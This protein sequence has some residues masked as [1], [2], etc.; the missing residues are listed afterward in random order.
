MLIK[1]LEKIGLTNKEARVYLAILELGES[2]INQIAKKSEIKRSTVYDIVEALQEEGYVYSTIYNKKK[3]YVAEN[4]GII[5]KKLEE[6]K[7]MAID[8]FPELSSMAN[9]SDK[10]PQIM[11]YYGNEGIKNLFYDTLKYPGQEVLAWLSQDYHKHFDK[12]FIE[13]IYI[14]KRVKNKI[15]ERAIA[16]DSSKMCEY[17]K[18]DKKVLRE[19]KLFKKEKFPF[20]VHVQLYGKNKIGIVSFPEKFCLIIVSKQI[21]NTLKSVFEINWLYS[22]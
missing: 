8:I 16:S 2:N 9:F 22:E 7:K 20:D 5:E 10:K 3:K 18:M 1:K 17:Q 13:E 21:Y 12:K 6:K 4:P 15:W 19:I 14:P 11:H